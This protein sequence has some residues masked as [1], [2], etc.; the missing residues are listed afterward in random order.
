MPPHDRTESN[1]NSSKLTLVIGVDGSG[2]TALLN[3]IAQQECTIALEPTNAPEARAVKLRTLC[4]SMDDELIDEHEGVFMKLNKEF[5][6]ITLDHQEAGYNV[7][8]SGS[9][10][11]TLVAHSLMRNIIGNQRK[12]VDNVVE[13]WLLSEELIKP[14]EIVFLHAPDD[15]IYQRIRKRQLKGRGDERF[16]GFNSPFFLSRYQNT[17]HSV[18]GKLA[19]ETTVKCVCLDT[20]KYSREATTEAYYQQSEPLADD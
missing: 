1:H 13:T 20:S 4:D 10:L 2:K 17:W 14:D 15:V 11:I 18:I 6:R 3:S 19:K 9:V 12:T 7:A 8:T 5:D 16:W